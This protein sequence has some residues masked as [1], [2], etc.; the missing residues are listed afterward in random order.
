MSR[1][2]EHIFST[3]GLEQMMRARIFARLGEDKDA[4]KQFSVKVFVPNTLEESMELAQANKGLFN[5]TGLLG[6]DDSGVGY[7]YF[8]FNIEQGL[9]KDK[10]EAI[11]EDLAAQCQECIRKMKA[12]R[13]LNPNEHKLILT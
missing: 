5:V 3:E 6:L 2:E 12:R 9:S 1:I 7:R 13:K 4:L 10:D 8:D 11:A